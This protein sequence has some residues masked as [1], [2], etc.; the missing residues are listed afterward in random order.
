MEE[1]NALAK[2]KEDIII[3]ID[4]ALKV[5]EEIAKKAGP[6]EDAAELVRRFR[7]ARRW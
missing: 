2:A 1:L 7:D 6:R 4:E 3:I 5:M